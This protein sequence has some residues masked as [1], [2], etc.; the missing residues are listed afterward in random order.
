MM[1]KLTLHVA[2]I[3]LIST[4]MSGC[5]QKDIG[6]S[7]YPS[8]KLRT[9]ATVRNGLL[10]GP[11]VMYFESGNKMSTANY[12]AGLLE[13]PS[14]AYYESGAVKSTAEYLSG[15][16]HGK[17]TSMKEDGTLINE[18]TFHGG[19]IIMDDLNMLETN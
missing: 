2:I 9:E 3:L 8:G 17:S 11:S 14:V 7:Y 5:W 15:I 4:T 18:V 12:R 1:R 16:L 19:K 13:G 6:H 10:D